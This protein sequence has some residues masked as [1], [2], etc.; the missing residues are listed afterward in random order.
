VL[1]R[2]RLEIA[3]EPGKR[4]SDDEEFV[5]STQ[6]IV[7]AWE[8]ETEAKGFERGLER[9]LEK[10]HEEGLVEGLVLAYRVRFGPVPRE[11]RRLIEATHDRQV[12]RGWFALV[13]T[14]TAEAFAEAVRAGSR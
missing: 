11:V 14:A 12:L 3:Q 1:L 8:H 5:M 4:T 13:Y 10:G 7:E 2:Y 6:D 9:G